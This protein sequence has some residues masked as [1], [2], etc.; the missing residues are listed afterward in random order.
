MLQII[1]WIHFH[2]LEMLN[3]HPKSALIY[4]EGEIF[5][6]F[7]SRITQ[8]C[9]SDKLCLQ[10]VIH[11]FPYRHSG[12]RD[13]SWSEICHF[14]TFLNVQLQSCEQ[15]VFCN[16]AFVSDVMSGLKSFMVNFMMA[17]SKVSSI[18]L[19][20][21]SYLRCCVGHANFVHMHEIHC[22][23]QYY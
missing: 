16:E 13:P 22:V 14:V 12:V 20:L 6:I 18:K 11:L 9:F 2:T 7:T 23:M 5:G 15:S 1:T 17:M 21:S 3:N 4:F 19:S 8:D 10:A